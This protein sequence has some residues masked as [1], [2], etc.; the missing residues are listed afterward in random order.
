MDVAP[1]QFFGDLMAALAV[2]ADPVR[3]A[4]AQAYLKSQREFLGVS[5]P[6]AR[7]IIK[8]GVARHEVSTHDDVIAVA[9]CCWEHPS[10]DARNAAVEI[11]MLRHTVLGPDDLVSIEPM[12]VDAETWAI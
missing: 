6:V 7:T 10:Y 1:E 3:A 12:L 8:K 5:V 4:Q 11:L 9:E 2:H